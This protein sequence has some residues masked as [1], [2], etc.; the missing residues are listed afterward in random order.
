MN[1]NVVS[2]IPKIQG[3]KSIEDYKPIVVANF[4][5]KIISKILADRLA[6]VVA[7][8]IS[9][10]QYGFV[11]GKHIQDCIGIALEA[12]ILLSKKVHRGNVAYKVDI[13]KAFDT[14][15]W[16]FLLN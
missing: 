14:L 13:H 1:S 16:K 4:K 9:P 11:Q 8:I 6:L 10:N 2:F 3:A 5:F 15:S 7:I 12:I